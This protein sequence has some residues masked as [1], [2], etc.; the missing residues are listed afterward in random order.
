MGCDFSRRKCLHQSYE[1]TTDPVQMY[2]WS[3]WKLKL[4]NE[5]F[6]KSLNS[7]FCQLILCRLEICFVLHLEKGGPIKL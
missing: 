5:R 4:I 6:Y 2:H 7:S 1:I 3:S